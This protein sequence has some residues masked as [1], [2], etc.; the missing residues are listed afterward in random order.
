MLHMAIVNEDPHMLSYL[1]QRGADVNARNCGSHFCAIDQKNNRKESSE[2]EYPV[3]SSRTNYE[4]LSYYGEYPLSFACVL[5]QEECVR[6]LIANRANL[7]NQDSN[8]NTALHM[9]VLNDNLVTFLL[10]Y[11]LI[12]PEKKL[13]Q[14]RSKLI[15]FYFK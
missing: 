2:S 15:D 4:G 1:L 9:L 10:G 3:L 14:T 13:F 6:I 8:G 7:N 12:L 11:R 5:N